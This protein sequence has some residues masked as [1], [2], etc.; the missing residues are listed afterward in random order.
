MPKVVVRLQRALLRLAARTALHRRTASAAQVLADWFV[1]RP[2]RRPAARRSRRLANRTAHVEECSIY[3]RPRSL[4]PVHRVKR[5]A[6]Q[7]PL[8]RQNPEPDP[9]ARESNSG[10]V[11][12]RWTI[13]NGRLVTGTSWLSE[14]R[15][16][17]LV[18]EPE[19]TGPADRIGAVVNPELFVGALG[20]FLRGRAGDPQLVCDKCEGQPRGQVAEDPRLSHGD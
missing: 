10:A 2:P 7:T 6:R 15:D 19:R 13:R 16:R 20:S 9:P 4:K 17:G 11:G 14:G 1:Q 18:D 5:T 3:R 8:T 12:V